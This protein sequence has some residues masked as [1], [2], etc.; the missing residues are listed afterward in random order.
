MS[1]KTVQDAW[2]LYKD[3]TLYSLKVGGQVTERG[4]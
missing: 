3:T 4:R 1:V 2:M